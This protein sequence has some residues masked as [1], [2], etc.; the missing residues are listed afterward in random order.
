MSLE[1]II[2]SVAGAAI[3]VCGV[4]VTAICADIRDQI[5]A[6]HTAKEEHET[7][8]VQLETRCDYMHG[9]GGKVTND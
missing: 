1:S 4:L 5:K 6:L 7:R 2:L 8:L 9:F 3:A